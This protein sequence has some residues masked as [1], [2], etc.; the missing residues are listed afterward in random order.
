MKVIKNF[1]E[2]PLCQNGELGVVFSSYLFDGGLEPLL[3]ACLVFLWQSEAECMCQDAA[4][5]VH[6]LPPTG[7][8]TDI[9]GD[10][11]LA[12]LK[13]PAFGC[14]EVLPSQRS[15]ITLQENRCQPGLQMA[16]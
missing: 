6:S 1:C 10:Q 12:R 4:A 16:Y 13:D 5:L 7:P 9:T 8:S 14:L 15:L 11:R 2:S 3:N